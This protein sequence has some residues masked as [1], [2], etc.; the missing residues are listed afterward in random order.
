MSINR[1]KTIH[2]VKENNKLILSLLTSAAIVL[3]TAC[4]DID[5]T[6]S[7]ERTNT[8]NRSDTDGQIVI[9]DPN[10]LIR[11]Y[12]DYMDGKSTL[13]HCDNLR[14]QALQ[15]IKTTIKE[16]INSDGGANALG[17]GMENAAKSAVNS[18]KLSRQKEKLYRQLDSQFSKRKNKKVRILT[19]SRT[20]RGQ[21]CLFGKPQ[22]FQVLLTVRS[23]TTVMMKQ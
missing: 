16:D 12:N 18:S 23:A 5:R 20:A 22:N 11:H 3:S 17:P 19:K 10:L 7:S 21:L 8:G 6:T 2:G 1:K 15:S 14:S 9:G 4:G 13:D